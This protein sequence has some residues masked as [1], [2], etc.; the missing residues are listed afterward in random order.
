MERN[1]AM[2][3]IRKLLAMAEGGATEGERSAFL[4]KA[5]HLMTVV[6]IDQATVDAAAPKE[7][8][9]LVEHIDMLRDD[10][11]SMMVKAKRELIFG[12]T[13]IFNCSALR[14]NDRAF[15]RVFGHTT[16]LEL[17]QMMYNSIMLQLLTGVEEAKRDR[18]VRG[19]T[20]VVN[21][22]H[23]YVRRVLGRLRDAQAATVADVS[24]GKPGTAL[25]LA[26]R[27]ALVDARIAT[28]YPKIRMMGSG[29]AA[30]Y[31]ARAYGRGGLDGSRADIG[32][33]RMDG[34]AA[35]RQLG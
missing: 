12:L 5:Q 16:D 34:R 35:P 13:K 17:F 29:N 10:K 14:V 22:A 7:R 18:D 25:V 24:T 28:I 8:H 6:G 23:G 1:D 32:Q 3:K 31:D 15:V 26:D 11:R 4:A 19:T 20:G 2:D 27:T 9:E 21:Y 30:R 33:T